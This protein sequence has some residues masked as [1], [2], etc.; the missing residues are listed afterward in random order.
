MDHEAIVAG[1]DGCIPKASRI[2]V[3]IHPAEHSH[4]R[5]RGSYPVNARSLQTVVLTQLAAIR[6]PKETSVTKIKENS[7]TQ[8]VNTY[9]ANSY[10]SQANRLRQY[11]TV[12]R[13][14]MAV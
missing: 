2:S 3:C 12:C 6:R 13:L 10:C 8:F 5:L 7:V 14:M 9:P 11:T 4:L 1:L